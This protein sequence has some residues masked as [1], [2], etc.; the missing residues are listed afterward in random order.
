VLAQDALGGVI[1]SLVLAI[2]LVSESRERLGLKSN[3]WGI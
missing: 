1:N 3:Q 2:G